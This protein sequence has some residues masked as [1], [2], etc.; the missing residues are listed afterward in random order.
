[1]FLQHKLS[2]WRDYRIL[3]HPME[4]FKHQDIGD[5]RCSIEKKIIVYIEKFI[6]KKTWNVFT[7]A[8]DTVGKRRITHPSRRSS[9][10]SNGEARFETASSIYIKLFT[11][12][13]KKKIVNHG[14]TVQQRL[15]LIIKAGNTT[16]VR[17]IYFILFASSYFP[18][19]FI[20]FFFQQKNFL[21]SKKD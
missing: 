14:N 3:Y 6:S 5:I 18:A 8:P 2:S 13:S 11:W 7:I 9:W 1:M 20:I 10:L 16:I 19:L 15:L 17:F 12:L 4:V 21:T